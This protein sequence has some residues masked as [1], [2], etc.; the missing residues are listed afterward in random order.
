LAWIGGLLLVIIILT[1]PLG[2]VTERKTYCENKLNS[3]A[4]QI[5]GGEDWSVEST[6]AYFDAESPCDLAGIAIPVDKSEYFTWAY[7]MADEYLNDDVANQIYAQGAFDFGVE[8]EDFNN[9][10]DLFHIWSYDETNNSW[11]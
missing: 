10:S 2:V 4:P 3:I 1:I 7:D 5:L 11:Y 6:C 9:E 8:P